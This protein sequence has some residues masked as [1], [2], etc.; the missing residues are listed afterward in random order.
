MLK[1]RG[2]MVKTESGGRLSTDVA[3]QSG[4]MLL[5]LGEMRGQGTR[6]EHLAREHARL[7]QRNLEIALSDQ[8]ILN[9]APGGKLIR[10]AR[11]DRENE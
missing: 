4:R 1:P 10:L 7:S 11:S 9:C 6:A 3:S 5:N 8:S 2:S